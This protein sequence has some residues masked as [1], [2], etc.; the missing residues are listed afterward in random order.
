MRCIF[1]PSNQNSVI[2]MKKSKGSITSYDDGTVVFTPYAE[3][4]ESRYLKKVFVSPQCEVRETST[5][6]KIVFTVQKKKNLSIESVLIN[7]FSTLIS[8]LKNL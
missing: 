1:A 4:G 8:K 2:I 7:H 3:T 5:D 6:I